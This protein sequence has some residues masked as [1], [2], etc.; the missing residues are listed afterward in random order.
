MIKSRAHIAFV[1]PAIILMIIILIIPVIVAATLSFTDYSLGNKTFNWV[2]WENYEALFKRS[3]YKKMFYASLTYVL[4]VVPF[5]VIFGLGAALLLSS[6]RFGSEIYK[7]IFFL[8]VM[9]TLLAMAIAWDFT[10][11]PIVGVANATLK[12]VITFLD[13]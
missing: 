3:S 6:L 8:P 12:M 2:S 9:A 10:L 5:S 4:I 7:T 11:D 1:T 13:P